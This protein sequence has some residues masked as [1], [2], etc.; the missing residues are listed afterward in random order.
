MFITLTASMKLLVGVGLPDSRSL[1][2]QSQVTTT[3][4]DRLS[5]LVSRLCLA[6]LFV[7][8]VW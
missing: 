6:E 3:C 5:S 2:K 7:C 8:K 4:L 1:K